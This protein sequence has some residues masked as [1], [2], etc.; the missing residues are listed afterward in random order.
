M[1]K[2]LPN[3]TCRFSRQDPGFSIYIGAEIA[4]EVLKAM[5]LRKKLIAVFDEDKET[6][7]IQKLRIQP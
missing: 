7:T 1:E 2:E 3:T 6:L 4:D 5:P